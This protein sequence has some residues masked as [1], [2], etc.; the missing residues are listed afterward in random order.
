MTRLR[1]TVL[2]GLAP[3][4]LS[5][6]W[7]ADDNRAAIGYSSG[8]VL[9][10][11]T[12]SGRVLRTLEARPPIGDFAISPDGQKVVFSPMAS[13]YGGPLYLLNVLTGKSEL[14][15]EDHYYVRGEVYSDPDFSPNGNELVFAIHAHAKGDLVE[16]SG[17]FATM[18]LRTKRVDVLPATTNI[19]GGVA[20]ANDPSWS[21][22]GKR[23][24]LNFESD[25]AV[26]DATGKTLKRLSAI[27]P[28]GEGIWLHGLGWIG[29]TC[30]VYAI[31]SDQRSA[32]RAPA[33]V[34]NLQTLK[35]VPVSGLLKGPPESFVGLVSFSMPIRVRALAGELN[36]EGTTH[37]W[38][39]PVK[40]P[41]HT[42][43]RLVHQ[44]SDQIPPGC[45]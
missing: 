39:I 4:L 27:V 32:N 7:A 14:L 16:A 33:R 45:Q 10:I 11:A 28:D 34:L 43:V 8:G 21:P 20:F 29:N 23:L 26:A 41:S 5:M 37:P 42:I 35:T 31:G 13:E 9:R 36:V 3:L 38:Q 19:E 44:P 6:L 30:V 2:V 15:A 22:D 40:D 1:L 25:A 24:L 18:D 12:E 17:P